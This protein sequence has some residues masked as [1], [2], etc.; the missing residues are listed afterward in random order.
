[1]FDIKGGCLFY[2]RYV[3]ACV[4]TC[5]IIWDVSE[6]TCRTVSWWLNWEKWM[7]FGYFGYYLLLF[8]ANKNNLSWIK[9]CSMWWKI[10]N[11]FQWLYFKYWFQYS[12]KTARPKCNLMSKKGSIANQIW[13][14][15]NCSAHLNVVCHSQNQ[16]HVHLSVCV[17]K[18]RGFI[19]YA[20]EHFW[21]TNTE[22]PAFWWIFMHQ[23]MGEL[24]L[25]R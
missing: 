5:A 14:R 2:T 21:A 24:S 4:F 13:L 19:T 23:F 8:L 25:F 10:F 20:W 11:L 17:R 15:F 12:N 18:Q 1:M 9:V 16:S 6:E 22:F 3:F 7:L